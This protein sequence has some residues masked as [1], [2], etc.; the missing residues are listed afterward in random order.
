MQKVDLSDSKNKKIGLENGMTL[1]EGFKKYGGKAYP[2]ML[3]KDRVTDAVN[4][5]FLNPVN[6]GTYDNP[7]KLSSENILLI[8]D[9][10]ILKLDVQNS[11]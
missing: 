9:F 1:K 2:L 4:C 8:N 5:D 7:K 11:I 10:I 6:I 3:I